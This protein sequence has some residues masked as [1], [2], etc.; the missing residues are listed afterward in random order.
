MTHAIER[1]EP[2][3]I[4]WDAYYGNHYLR[5]DFASNLLSRE[6]AEGPLLDAACGVGYGSHILATRL[7]RR[8]VGVDRDERALA[9]ARK[10][11]A[12][13]RI[14]FLKDDCQSLANASEKA[15]YAAIVSFETLEHLPRPVD[16][17]RACRGIL[18]NGGTFVVST[19][20]SRVS[21]P[22]GK[23][24][25][26]YHEREYT[27]GEFL[28]LVKEA[29]FSDVTLHGQRLTEIGKLR[30]EMRGELHALASNPF[31]RAGRWLQRMRGRRFAPLLPERATD[32]E[33]V[34]LAD[35]AASDALG[36]EGPFVY[37][38]VARAN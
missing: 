31:I 33:I 36:T 34:P 28:A 14:S 25:W 4:W 12:H 13:E 29:G 24:D 22:D 32:F 23:P 7:G 26:E 27:A 18:A 17:L 19:P 15:P 8:V 9:L 30:A 21:S 38:V 2:G 20:N 35:A 1:I 5:Y 37:V 11:F 3:T 6:A 16:F 10:H